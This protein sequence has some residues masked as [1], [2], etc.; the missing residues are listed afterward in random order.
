M[1]TNSVIWGLYCLIKHTM[2][3]APFKSHK[4]RLATVFHSVFT[5]KVWDHV[6]QGAFAITWSFCFGFQFFLYAGAFQQTE[7][8]NKWIF[9]KIVA[10]TL[11]A[12]CLGEILNL[13]II[14]L[15]SWPSQWLQ[16][17]L[18]LR[19]HCQRDRLQTSTSLCSN[20]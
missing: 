3:Y 8:S 9:G 7:V 11:W 5:G 16:L 12:P 17:I 15:P 6:Y 4:H 10:I 13:E 1:W 14:K 19:R 2:G 18:D 20:G